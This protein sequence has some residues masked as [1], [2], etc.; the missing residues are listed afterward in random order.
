MVRAAGPKPGGVLDVVIGR[1]D[2]KR[3]GPWPGRARDQAS[4][5]SGS[6]GPVPCAK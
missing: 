4:T 3:G 2:N 6:L 5:T 1:T